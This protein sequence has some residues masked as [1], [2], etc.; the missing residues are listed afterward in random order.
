MVV[1]VEVVVD[2]EMEVMAGVVRVD[3]KIKNLSLSPSLYL[4]FNIRC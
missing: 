1:D 2:G 4:M 3:E